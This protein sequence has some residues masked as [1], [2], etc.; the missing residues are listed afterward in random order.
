MISHLFGKLIGFQ[1]I[2]NIRPVNTFQVQLPFLQY[3]KKDIKFVAM[4]MMMQDYKNAKAVG[5]IIKEA[6]EGRDAVVIA[7][8]DF[9][10][11]IPA[12]KAKERT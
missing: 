6:I 2:L 7:S 5:Y 11:Y 1:T 4:S 3:F 10:H 8:T 9:S 12:A